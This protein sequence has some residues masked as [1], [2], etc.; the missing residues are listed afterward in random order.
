[1]S[2]TSSQVTAPSSRRSAFPRPLPGTE[3]TA[4]WADVDAIEPA[5]QEQLRNV[6][7][8]PWTRRLAVMP[9]VHYGKGATV[10]S[11]IAM[12]GA[13]APSAVGVDIGC[14][15]AAVQTSLRAEDLP[16]D[17]RSLRLAIEAAIPVGFHAHDDAADLRDDPGLAA[18]V[19][20]HLQGFTELRAPRVADRRT[21]AIAQ[22]GTLGGGNH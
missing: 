8:L 18:R 7:A 5:A 20:T 17:L 21:R 15:M 22:W 19:R 16:E 2:T 10:G 1:M 6:A 3:N 14:G 4:L 9:D 12:E 13:V 11:V